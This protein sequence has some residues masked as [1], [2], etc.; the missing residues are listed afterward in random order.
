VD[1]Y[2]L[3]VISDLE[4]N[5]VRRVARAVLYGIHS[6]FPPPY[7]TGQEGG[8][9][10]ISEKKLVKRDAKFLKGKIILSFLF[11]GTNWTVQ[12]PTDKA[13]GIIVEIHCY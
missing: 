12:L 2:I 10:P 6:I 7:N 11:N 1:D 9:D 4:H 3:G 5:L 13:G 8:K